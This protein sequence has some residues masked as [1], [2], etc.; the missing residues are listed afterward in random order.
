MIDA[1]SPCPQR[2]LLGRFFAADIEDREPLRGESIGDLKQQRRFAD[3]W[4]SADENQRASDDPAAEKAVE[5]SHLGRQPLKFIRL[6]FA[7]PDRLRRSRSAFVSNRLFSRRPT[8]LRPEYSNFGKEEQLPVH[9]GWSWPH[10]RHDQMTF[11]LFHSTIQSWRARRRRP[12][13]PLPFSKRPFRY[14]I[15]FSFD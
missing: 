15:S 14:P 6:H 1:K 11:A 3:S 7:N 4:L 9:F 2:R 10:S 12:F 8:L 5:F 13:A